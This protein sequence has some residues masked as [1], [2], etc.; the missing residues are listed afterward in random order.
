MIINL[1]LKKFSP[2]SN[3]GSPQ[4]RSLSTIEGTTAT[5]ITHQSQPFSPETMAPL[6]PLDG[7]G[8]NSSQIN[9]IGYDLLINLA[10]DNYRNKNAYP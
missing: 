10:M 4:D 6:S 2:S 1:L 7:S 8:N 9:N 5:Q 3:G